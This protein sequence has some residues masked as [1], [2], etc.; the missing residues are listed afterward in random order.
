MVLL[1]PKV[2]AGHVFQGTQL[3]TLIHKSPAIWY[4]LS[5]IWHHS[6]NWK[7]KDGKMVLL[8]Y[9]LLESS[10]GAYIEWLVNKLMKT[11]NK[12]KYKDTCLVLLLQM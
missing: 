7:M 3:G 5:T 8:A 6:K 12:I 11:A 4:D 9:N 1:V 2:Q 10:T